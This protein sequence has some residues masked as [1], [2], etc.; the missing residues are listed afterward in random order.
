MIFVPATFARR[1]QTWRF[2]LDGDV[3]SGL[4][5]KK[6]TCANVA[7]ISRLSA[8]KTLGIP[9]GSG[10]PVLH[11]KHEIRF[12]RRWRSGGMAKIMPAVNQPA[13]YTKD[14]D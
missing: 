11:F 9:A 10:R 3:K 8:G 13:I 4:R 1:W 7:R 12:D 2:G 5:L 14:D 6:R